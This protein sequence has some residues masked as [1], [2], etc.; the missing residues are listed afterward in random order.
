MAEENRKT[1]NY[2]HFDGMVSQNE[3]YG[4]ERDQIF[5][6]E[7][8]MRIGNG[9]LHSVPGPALVATLPIPTTG[10][11][12]DTLPGVQE[13]LVQVHFWS[14]NTGIPP[15]TLNNN[16]AAQENFIGENDDIIVWISE[17]S[18]FGTDYA[19]NTGSG[20]KGQVLHIQGASITAVT[21]VPLPAWVTRFTFFGQEAQS[22]ADGHSDER[23]YMLTGL[24]Y[25]AHFNNKFAHAYFSWD[26]QQAYFMDAFTTQG[27]W[28]KFGNQFYIYH[29]LNGEGIYRYVMQSGSVVEPTV[30]PANA[31][32]GVRPCGLSRT[33]N[34]LYALYP[35]NA[36]FQLDKNSLAVT[37]QWNLTSQLL[38]AYQFPNILNLDAISDNLIYITQRKD[39]AGTGRLTFYYFTVNDGKLTA[40]NPTVPYSIDLNSGQNPGFP[41]ANHFFFR[42][43]YLYFGY[44]G[45]ATGRT[46]FEKVGTLNC[47][48]QTVPIGTPSA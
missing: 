33:P 10:C 27:P 13:P 37:N 36:L 30:G 40:I 32:G 43:G 16:C 29:F 48:G 7:N 17:R 18:G 31:L 6:L 26:S 47:P 39:S 11:P 23:S 25:S 9:D 24:V 35:S 42:K 8:I 15:G 38:P 34:H 4:C 44:N 19:T 12:E 28:T 46:N 21:R 3:R 45:I 5:W 1:E 14:F 22:G 20:G 41:G 2:R